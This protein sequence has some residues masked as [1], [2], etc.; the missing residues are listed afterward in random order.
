MS[1]LEINDTAPAFTLP[2]NAEK[3]ISLSDYKGRYLVLYFYPRD[4]TPGCTKEAIAF[5]EHKAAFDALGADILGA[6]KDTPAKHDKFIAKH[7]LGID[8]VSDESGEMLEAY[9]VWQEKKNYGKTYMGI[10]RS[11]FLI[12]PTGKI[13]HIWPKV[14]VKD[15]VEAVLNTLKSL[16]DA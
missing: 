11:T 7:A 8:L 6:S 12:D 2:A 15:H 1:L 3:T 14:R 13:V 5:T 9:G 10:V 16:K 4:D